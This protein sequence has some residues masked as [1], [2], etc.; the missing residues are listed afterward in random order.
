MIADLPERIKILL[1]PIISSN[2]PAML[3]G[4][5]GWR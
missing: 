2:T 1:D 5:R 4:P 3:Y